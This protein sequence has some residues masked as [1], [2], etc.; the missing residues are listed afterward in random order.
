MR[1]RTKIL[2]LFLVSCALELGFGGYYYLQA[3]GPLAPIIAEHTASLDAAQIPP[4]SEI[5][6]DT[7]PWTKVAHFETSLGQVQFIVDTAFSLAVAWIL[8]I[9]GMSAAIFRYARSLAHTTHVVRGLYI[10]IISAIYTVINIPLSISGYVTGLLRGTAFSTPDVVIFGVITDFFVASVF[11]LLSF[12]PFYWITDRFPRLWWLMAGAFFSVFA[13]FT[14]YISPL[15]LDPLYTSS[16]PMPEGDMRTRI[17]ALAHKAGVDVADRIYLAEVSPY[18]HD[19][20][21]YVSGLFSTKRITLDDTLLQ[22]YSPEEIEFIVAHELGHTYH[23]HIWKDM[24]YLAL[25][26][27]ITYGI[28]AATLQF[29]LKRFSRELGARRANDIVLYPLLM[30]L[31]S[32][33]TLALAPIQSDLS[34]RSEHESDVFAVAVTQNPQAGIDGFKKLSYQSFVDPDPSPLL[35]WMFGTHPTFKERIEYLESQK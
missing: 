5:N 2:I 31:I 3:T 26:T 10:I 17:E 18:T 29:I 34:R 16:V 4:A 1:T 24:G 32:F 25:F 8:I 12:I 11:A 35:Q 19:T 7:D 22:F 21:A 14:A 6:L 20:N 27:I 13:V 30:T 33:I 23:N 9:G 28:L 15:V